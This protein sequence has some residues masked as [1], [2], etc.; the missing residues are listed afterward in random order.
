M[1]SSVRDLEKLFRTVAESQDRV[2]VGH[3]SDP[4]EARRR[5]VAAAAA[6]GKMG[7]P[8]RRVLAWAGAVGAVAAGTALV[9]TA[10][11]EQRP[12]FQV[13]VDRAGVIGAE[14]SAPAAEPLVLR[15]S[16]GSEVVLE[17]GGRGRVTS[18]DARDAHFAFEGGVARFSVSKATG[19]AWTVDAGEFHVRPGSAARFL[20]GFDVPA[21]TVDLTVEEGSAT[22]SAPCRSEVAGAGQHLHLSCSASALVE[23]PRPTASTPTLVPSTIEAPPSEPPSS[24]PHPA[25]EWRRLAAASR[26]REA[27]DAAVAAGFDSQCAAASASDLLILGDAARLAGDG[28]HADIAYRTL[29]RRFPS[30]SRAS[31]AAFDL[32]KLAFDL[33][34][35]HADAARWFDTY[36]AEQP[37]GPLVREALGRSMEAHWRSADRARAR[38]LAA[39]YMQRYPGGPHEDL[40]RRIVEE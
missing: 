35:S 28:A 39:Q 14:V 13:G 40:A 9:L 32:G 26:Y 37:S 2:L 3:E 1:S 36:L 4:G 27:V 21:D 24:P 30:D 11:R 15:F 18:L 5:F 38:D 34:G 29:R 16:D 20:L 6:K 31:V 10:V 23:L 22:L 7:S 8:R 25:G 12:S 33:R 17:P 19:L